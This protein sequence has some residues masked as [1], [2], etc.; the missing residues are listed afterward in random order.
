[1]EIKTYR[2][3][4]DILSFDVTVPVSESGVCTNQFCP[5]DLLTGGIG[6]LNPINGESE[7]DFVEDCRRQILG[8]EKTGCVEDKLELHVAGLMAVIMDHIAVCGRLIFGDLLIYMDCFSLL[9]KADECDDLY[10][11]EMYPR[12]LRTV[13]DLYPQ[14]VLNTLD[15][16]PFSGSV[17]EL[18]LDSIINKNKIS[19]CKRP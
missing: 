15:L 9:L 3:R 6:I 11:K 16:S 12:L 14:M 5:D 4:G 19:S 10:I 17:F 13:I 1:M 18:I 8:M 7:E 2:I